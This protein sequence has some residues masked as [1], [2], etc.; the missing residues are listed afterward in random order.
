MRYS[1]FVG[2]VRLR[3]SAKD[4]VACL[5]FV[6][7]CGPGCASSRVLVADDWANGRLDRGTRGWNRIPLHTEA[8]S[9]YYLHLYGEYQRVER[10]PNRAGDLYPVNIFAA[11][12][13]SE[14]ALEEI[15]ACT[16]AP[17]AH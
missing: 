14:R 15:A 17:S 5:D 10:A 4:A 9:S 13:P 7:A 8:A 16:R 1:L 3:T 12:R 6:G 2:S 11:L